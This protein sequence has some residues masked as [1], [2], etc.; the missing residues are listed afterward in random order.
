MPP[1]KCPTTGRRQSLF[2][3]TSAL[4]DQ[5]TGGRYV[6]VEIDRA[7]AALVGLNVA[8]VQKRGRRRSA[9]ELVGSFTRWTYGSN[10]R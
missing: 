6:D 8:D 7:A 5:L 4:A 10:S 3:V 1:K 2:G 9:A